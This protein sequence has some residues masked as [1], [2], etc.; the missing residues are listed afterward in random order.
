MCSRDRG[1]EPSFMRRRWIVMLM[2]SLLLVAAPL[3]AQAGF[4]EL[5]HR[6][7]AWWQGKS[8]SAGLA[9]ATEVTP[10]EEGAP[11]G[12]SAPGDPGGAGA[13]DGS[14]GDGSGDDVG[15]TPGNV[16][17]PGMCIVPQEPPAVVCGIGSGFLCVNTPPGGAAG[18][19]IR[20]TGTIDRQTSVLAS[21]RIVAQAE[22]TKTMTAVDTANPDTAGCGSG[23]RGSRPFCIDA[24]GRFAAEVALPE[25]GPYTITVSASRLSGEPASQSVRVSSVIAPQLAAEGITFDPDVQA[26]PSVDATHVNVAVK[27]L[28]DC[29]FCDFIGA[30]TGGIEVT[31]ENRI[32]D[33]KGQERRISCRTTVEQGGQ[34]RFQ[35]G[36][37]VGSG[38]NEI[39]VRACNA[40]VGSGACPGTDGV[41]FTGNVPAEASEGLSLLSP[42]PQPSYDADAYPSIPWKFQM[43]GA[44]RCVSIRFNR[45]APQ[46]ICR[47]AGGVYSLE[48]IP[49][50]GINVASIVDASGIES[51][52]WTFG[53]GKI[54]SPFGKSGGGLRVP[55]AVELAVPART[56][57]E[58]LL[59]LLN[60]FLASDE[61]QTFLTDALKGTGGEETA[62]PDDGIEKLIPKCDGSSGISGVGV[63]LRGDPQ[64]GALVLKELSFDAEKVALSLVADGLEVGVDLVPE[65]ELP[66]LP[67][68][69]AFRKAR[70]D[71]LLVAEKASDGGAL[72]LLSSP[73]DDCDFK[74]DSYCTH[75]PAAL[76]PANFVGGANS[77]GGFI[78]CE[79]ELA[80]GRADEACDAINS[81][82]AQTG[83][84][85][86]KVLD[87]L[88]SMLYCGLSTSLTR[89]A[90]AGIAVPPISIGCPDGERCEGILSVLPQVKLPV[91]IDLGGNPAISREGIL[92]N[93]GLSFGSEELFKETPSAVRIDSAG[94]ILGE[95]SGEASLSSPSAGGG[96][97]KAAIALDALNALLY[98]ATAQGDG[99]S[100]RGLLDLDVDE[101]FFQDLGFD[102]VESCDGFEPVEGG[103]TEP[104]MLCNV[105]PR[106]S[107]L[108]GSSLST[109]GYLDAKHPILLAVRG[110]RALGPRIALVTE[111]EL[112]VVQ[113]GSGEAAV[114]SAAADAAPVV[115]GGGLISIELGGIGL[116]FYALE[117]DGSKPADE[118][119]NLAVKRDAQGNPVIRSMRDSGD[120]WD[121]PIISVDL[122]MLLGVAVGPVQEDAAAESGFSITLGLL[123]DR[124]CVVL[125]PVPGSNATTVPSVG[126]VSALGDKVKLGISAMGG[127]G[128]GFQI[129]LPRSFEFSADDDGGF[130]MLGLSQVVLGDQGL[131]LGFE[132]E[133]NTITVAV[134][135]FLQQRLH[136]GGK[137]VEYWVPR[138][139]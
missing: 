70:L 66:P 30:S 5:V 53:W 52:A 16:G 103:E 8:L 6:A 57:Q 114:A 117:V 86:E 84:V 25:R 71:L 29:Q 65:K 22:Y 3:R 91:G 121:G 40:A 107:E 85:G 50:T 60:H 136:E 80:K 81:L 113:Q 134:K 139:P 90:R 14:S 67:L 41:A 48:L 128:A 20:I 43:G 55:S 38:R 104:P 82:N 111:E 34:G 12:G 32:R 95:G 118:Y 110:N 61:R 33:A 54:A 9:A 119:G 78:R 28:T 124:S 4:T 72:L 93:A 138:K 36:V 45:Q 11:E 94:I 123:P 100:Q 83:I 89:L 10:A 106:V 131:N 125:T 69:I 24:E 59:P 109:Y 116:S 133:R 97:V 96:D 127:E 2:L 37:P 115:A 49:R 129:P 74:S 105:R 42:P 137:E 135:A 64:V 120:P 46:Q 56:G 35:V 39:S 68:T 7:A 76:I 108:L 73:H 15:D 26:T 63:R 31:V 21:I 27:L 98:A 130:G 44:E 126:L 132:P 101:A 23:Q 18:E 87:A 13:G 99:R 62:A 75:Q 122:T 102:F 92:F 112:P 47:D 77:W 51:Y 17:T 79:T 1:M 88:N 58:I 19:G